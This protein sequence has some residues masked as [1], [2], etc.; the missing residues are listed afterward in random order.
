MPSLQFLPTDTVAAPVTHRAPTAFDM[1]IDEA[2]GLVR[3][4][5]QGDW[6]LDEAEDYISE[7]TEL[8]DE[9]R[10]RFGRA[11]VLADQRGA[12]KQS[13]SVTDRLCEVHATM[14]ADTD[15]LAIV[16]DSSLAK[17]RMR[18]RFTHVG[19]Q[20]FLSHMAAELWLTAWP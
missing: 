4:R 7:L 18:R 3:T 6:T 8:V 2:T 15:R 9:C 11:R 12:P 19:S 10:R 14:Y 20:A 13:E 17:G 1:Q 5:V 16:V